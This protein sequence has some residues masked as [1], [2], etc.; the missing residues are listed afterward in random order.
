ML[1]LCH[2]DVMCSRYPQTYFAHK[3]IAHILCC[4]YPFPDKLFN[5]EQIIPT[6]IGVNS[7]LTKHDQLRLS[8]PVLYWMTWIQ[9]PYFS[10]IRICWC[11]C[12]YSIVQKIHFGDA[13]WRRRCDFEMPC[14]ASSWLWDLRLGMEEIKLSWRLRFSKSVYCTFKSEI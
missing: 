9:R 7:E 12:N 5:S 14:S 10:V 13:S 2:L 3:Y 4:D 1:T 8:D 6:P 11:I